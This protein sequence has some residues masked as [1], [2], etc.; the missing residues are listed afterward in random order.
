MFDED[1]GGDA[2]FCGRIL[3]ALTATTRSLAEHGQGGRFVRAKG[4]GHEIFAADEALV[5]ATIDEVLE[6]AE[7]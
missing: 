7:R 1:C 5:L 6:A 3:P 2:E 4:A